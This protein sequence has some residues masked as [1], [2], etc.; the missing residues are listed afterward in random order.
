[1]AKERVDLKNEAIKIDGQY[2]EDALAG[3][4]TLRTTGRESL[5]VELNSYTTGASN[6][7]IVKSTRYPAR[8]ITVEFLLRGKD[9]FELR[10]RLNHLNNLLSMDEADFVFNDEPDKFFT[11]VPIISASLD[12]GKGWVNGKWEI[13]CS[14]P[15]K[16]SIEPIEI[17]PTDIEDNTAEFT[18]VYNGTYPARPILMA[19]FAGAKTGGDYSDDGDCG[20]VAF[21]DEDENIIQLGNPDAID[22]DEYSK[23]EQLINREFTTIQDWQTTGGKSYG[24]KAIDGSLSVSNIT[25]TYWC[26]G[27]GQTLK[28]AKPSHVNGNGWHGPILWKHTNGA[29]NFELATVHR[30]CVNAANEVGT[31]ECGLY[32]QNGSAYKMVAGFVI[33]KTASGNS[34]T[35]RYI[36]NGN[37]VGSAAID[38]S[39]YNTNFGYCQRTA[40]YKT[41]YYNKKKKK[42]QDKKIKKA[43]TRS[44]ISTYTYTQSNLNSSIKK[45]GSVF[46]FKIG[47]LPAKTFIDTDA[48]YLPA[49]NVSFHFG[50]NGGAPVLHTNAVHTVRFTRNPSDCFSDIP[51]VFTSGDIVEADCNDASVYIKHSNTEDGHFAPQ[52]GA[53]GNDWEDFLI[54]KGSNTIQA[55]WSDWVNE[56][57]KP[58]LKI[59][60]NEV[61]I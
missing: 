50:R 52:F 41:Q 57:Y 10:D 27:A 54:K 40:V 31:F 49:H 1:M 47:N 29:I 12:K 28:F 46:T 20:F 56:N 34:G 35:V 45:S 5:Q 25:D 51:N 55:V 60:Y 61:Y 6:G 14:D 7:E 38:L 37:V 4:T 33:E 13:F 23:A 17:T 22:I 30:I 18:F 3:Y 32:N 58:T 26:N 53:L 16:Y 2:I 42:W 11:G 39:Y 59:I 19:E 44:V 15:F 21:M 8:T 9:P 24:D 48:E 36:V 43:K